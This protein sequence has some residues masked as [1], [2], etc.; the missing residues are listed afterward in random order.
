MKSII[1]GGLGV[2]GG[3][4]GGISGPRL[5]VRRKTARATGFLTAAVLCLATIAGPNLAYAAHGGGGG[6]FHGGGFGGFH[7]GGFGGFHAGA[8]GGF[9]GGAFHGGGFSGGGVHPE[10]PSSAGTSGFH[11]DG[12][13]GGSGSSAVILRGGAQRAPWHQSWHGGRYGWRSGYDPYLWSADGLYDDDY[14]AEQ[15]GIS[16]SWYY[17]SDPAG[18]YPYVAQCSVGWQMVPAG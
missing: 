15:P 16:Q 2:R 10:A 8:V 18:Y 6:G 9:H 1:T 7:G 4:P 3:V 12:V 17:C 13:A 5:G 14:A 11:A